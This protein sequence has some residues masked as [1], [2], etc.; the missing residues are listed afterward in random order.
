MFC[1]HFQG[2]KY[3]VLKKKYRH[4]V[5]EKDSSSSNKE[6]NTSVQATFEKM[7]ESEQPVYF[8]KDKQTSSFSDVHQFM[9]K[10]QNETSEISTSSNVNLC[11]WI[12]Q[13]VPTS[14][15]ISKAPL[16]ITNDSQVWYAL[17]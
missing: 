7:L 13:D 5:H 9:Q 11:E 14:D 6:K 12:T 17:S 4:L 1:L 3:I 8:G 10:S 2:E 16:E 15:T